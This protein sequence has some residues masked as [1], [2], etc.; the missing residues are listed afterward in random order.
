MQA[1]FC[2]LSF[3]QNKMNKCWTESEQSISNT[4]GTTGN[5]HSFWNKDF[6]EGQEAK[7][8]F[9]SKALIRELGQLSLTL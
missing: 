8:K 7:R 5:A 1:N 3:H 2:Y 9:T 6:S 4:A